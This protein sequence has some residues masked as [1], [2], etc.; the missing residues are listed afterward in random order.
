MKIGISFIL[1]LLLFSF[2]LLANEEL[3]VFSRIDRNGSTYVLHKADSGQVIP[4]IAGNE[5]V[6][7]LLAS[8]SGNTEAIV[9]G[10]ITYQME[11]GNDSRTLKPYFVVTEIRPISLAEIG[12]VPREIPE[13]TLGPAPE[14][15]YPRTFSFPVTTEIASAMTLTSTMLLMN[16]LTTGKENKTQ[17]QINTGLFLSA[18]AMA[19]ILFIYDQL[20]GK[21][22]P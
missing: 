9:R 12:R 22:K 11:G 15:L 18:G 21:T 16:A 20:S 2:P 5:E 1:S 3:S 4:F 8:L 19:T 7:N 14:L 6:K 13:L 10:H 17:E